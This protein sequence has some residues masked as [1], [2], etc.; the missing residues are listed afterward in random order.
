M[1]QLYAR[2]FTQIL[3]SSIA[4]DFRTRHI[5]E[6]L[7][8]VCTTGEDGGIVDMTK[9]ALARR[10][11]VPQ[12]E[13]NDAIARLESPDLK[14]RDQTMEGRR[15]T[16]LDDH[17]DWGWKIVNWK[18]YDR[19]R[20]RA[21][22]AARVAKH[23]AGAGRKEDHPAENYHEHS[24]TVLHLINEH[25]GKQFLETD[26]NLSCISA[27]LSEKGVDLDGVK[28][29]LQR[30]WTLWKDAFTSDNP[31][32]PMREYYQPSTLFRPKNFGNYY[33][34][35]AQPIQ[36]QPTDPADRNTNNANRHTIGQY[37]NIGKIPIPPAAAKPPPSA[38]PP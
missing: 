14:S 37:D 6:D 18:E 30:Q 28:L 9:E 26:S 11:N 7:L 8:K 10:F 31:P 38:P 15:L 12:D 2:V 25:S 35:R 23:R 1:S 32:K 13:L 16:R 21:E 29:M 33:A 34:A 36:F 3:D 20:T 19:L 5:F 17:R 27:R 4:E 24:R 22:V